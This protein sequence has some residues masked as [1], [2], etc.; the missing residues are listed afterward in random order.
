MTSVVASSE[1]ED[2]F[3][4][5]LNPHQCDE[6][7]ITPYVRT[8]ESK[9]TIYLVV[10]GAKCGGCLSKI[11]RAVAD[12]P[13][14]FKGRLNLSS[15]KM[16]VQWRG[17]LTA[18]EIATTISNL[19]YET[20]PYVDEAANAQNR[21]EQRRLL[22]ALGIAGFSMANIMLLSVSVWSGHDEMTDTTRQLMHA[23]S[24]IIAAPAM[25]F[26]GRFFFLSAWRALN[27]KRVNMDVPVSLALLLAFSVSVVETYVGGPHAYFDACVMLMFFLL[28]GR[29]L[30]ARL[31][32]RAFAA[33]HKLTAMQHRS[34]RRLG[35]NGVDDVRAD[36]IE[37][38]D[39]L[40]VAMGERA[41]IDMRL[42]SHEAEVDESLGH[43]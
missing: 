4:S 8:T 33:A 40:L 30:D 31:R 9:N 5:A 21:E 24:G 29:F 26:S 35:E 42:T 12:L 28:L 2:R 37:T 25:V 10:R 23:I 11:E 38:G 41:L 27:N 34:V 18:E 32:Q 6:R 14:V 3:S 17:E 36:E 1:P 7:F 39:K 22:V 19:G 15:G 20:A 43:R 13:G 16:C